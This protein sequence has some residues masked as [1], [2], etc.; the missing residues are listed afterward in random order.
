[1]TT[2]ESLDIIDL[3]DPS[4]TRFADYMLSGIFDGDI[5]RVPELQY[6][7]KASD[8]KEEVSEQVLKLDSHIRSF[9]FRKL[10]YDGDA[11][12]AF[13]GVA[14][15]YSS[16]SGLCLLGM[17]V[18]AGKFATGKPGAQYTFGLS[19][20]AWTHTAQPVE[21]DAEM[22]V[23]DCPRRPQFPSWTWVG[24]KGRAD[25]S[26]TA[27][28]GK[29]EDNPP[30]WEDNV[31]VEFFK[32]MTSRD[33]ARYQWSSLVSRDDAAGNRWQRGD[34]AGGLHACSEHGY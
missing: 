19:I 24:W 4:E 26:A 18:W 11:L 12:N 29:E 15:R 30:G 8:V 6:G 14:A 17:P 9:T 31:H 13:L 2:Q 3:Y 28:A 22:Y 34:T 10:S 27:A 20:S 16:N 21:K 33:W 23:V 7:F 1:M 5:H 25:F 32:A